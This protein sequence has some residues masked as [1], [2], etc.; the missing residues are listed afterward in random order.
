MTVDAQP[1]ERIKNALRP[2][3]IISR[4]VCVFNAQNEHTVGLQRKNPVVK[5]GSCS[6]YVKIARW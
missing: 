4:I 6:T 2:L 3:R 5:R 1:C